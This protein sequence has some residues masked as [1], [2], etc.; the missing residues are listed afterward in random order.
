[1]ADPTGYGIA[2]KGAESCGCTAATA[3]RLYRRFGDVCAVCVRS[4]TGLADDTSS[5][6][7]HAR[8]STWQI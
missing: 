8:C 4:A 6:R 3:T 1:M 7:Q 5:L 2:D